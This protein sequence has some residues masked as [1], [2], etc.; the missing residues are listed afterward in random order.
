MSVC[1]A[2]VQSCL[3]VGQIVV[4]MPQEKVVLVCS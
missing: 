4:H 1:V 3:E 2:S